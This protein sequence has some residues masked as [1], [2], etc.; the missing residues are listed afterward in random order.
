M[1]T[2]TE[3]PDGYFGYF[4][5]AQRSLDD[6][7]ITLFMPVEEPKIKG[8]NVSRLENE[9]S[10]VSKKVE[11]LEKEERDANNEKIESPELFAFRNHECLEMD[12]GSYTY[13]ICPG[14]RAAQHDIGASKGDRGTGLGTW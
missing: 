14:K 6:D 3:I 11:N 10:A 13:S 9:V 2:P 12:S 7:I 1:A 8:E 4:E 5:F